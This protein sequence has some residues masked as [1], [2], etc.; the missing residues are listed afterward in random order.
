MLRDVRPVVRQHLASRNKQDLN[1]QGTPLVWHESSPAYSFTELQCNKLHQNEADQWCSW[2]HKR[3][4]SVSFRWSLPHCSLTSVHACQVSC[5]TTGFC[6]ALAAS[7]KVLMDHWSDILEHAVGT[8]LSLC[9]KN[10]HSLCKTSGF[11]RPCTSSECCHMKSYKRIHV[12]NFT[13]DTPTNTTGQHNFG[14]IY[15][16]VVSRMGMPVHF[17]ARPVGCLAHADLP[18]CGLLVEFTSLQFD[19]CAG[20]VL[21]QTSG[22]PRTCKYFLLQAAGCCGPL[23]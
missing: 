3:H 14:G 7:C 1:A 8:H 23:V 13:A 4:W 17:H 12:A 22:M 9:V 5:Q 19:E 16:I 15:C 11:R 21:C 6:L 20:Q 18:C 10:P 2:E